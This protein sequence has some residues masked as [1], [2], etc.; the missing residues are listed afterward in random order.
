M[1]AI[2]WRKAREGSCGS[3]TSKSGFQVTHLGCD[4]V[5]RGAVDAVVC[6]LRGFGMAE[7]EGGQQCQ[8]TVFT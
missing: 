4:M 2:E 1:G 3:A 6:N 7:G 5:G 8:N